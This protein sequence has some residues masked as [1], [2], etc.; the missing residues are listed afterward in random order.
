MRPQ[1]PPGHGAGVTLKLGR[2]PAPGVTSPRGDGL[3]LISALAAA[4]GLLGS[5]PGF[6]DRVR[7]AVRLEAA[8]LPS[9]L[10][11]PP[12]AVPHAH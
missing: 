12:A 6:P 8:G 11:A 2:S 3:V 1:E 7:G 4:L 5:R 10:A 9:T